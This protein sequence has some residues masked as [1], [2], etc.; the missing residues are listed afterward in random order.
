MRSRDIQ[1]IDK[2][3]RER[4]GIALDM[5]EYL[6]YQRLQS[7]C[8]AHAVATVDCLVEHLRS[9]PS[10]ELH[11]R[12]IEAFTNHETSFF[13]DTH[14]FEALASTVLPVLF[15]RAS[16]RPV[17]IWSSGC[18]SGQEAYSIGILVLEHNPPCRRHPSVNILAS[19]ISARMVEQARSGMYS[20]Y[21]I[22]RGIDLRIR[23]KYFHAHGDCWRISNRLAEL[24]DFRVINV[25]ERPGTLPPMDI[26]FLR[27]VLIYFSEAHRR[28]VLT[29]IH[30]V[31]RPGGYLFLG[32]P[33]TNIGASNEFT[34][35]LHGNA[36]YFQAR[37]TN[38]PSIGQVLT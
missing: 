11:D 25:L 14:P 31:L 20:A 6:V 30:R 10:A 28:R 12:L 37:A 33:E 1:Y 29:D 8:R 16:G 23:D 4:S 32:A 19:D 21:Q 34:K 2:L 36:V 35:I 24:I 7:L 17:Y 26:V 5:E 18:A 15:A 3:V 9:H 13:R 38:T 22:G 27:N